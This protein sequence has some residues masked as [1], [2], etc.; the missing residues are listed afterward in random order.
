MAGSLKSRLA[1]I[2][3]L[4]IALLSLW[5]TVQQSRIWRISAEE[6]GRIGDIESKFSALKP[7][8]AGVDLVGYLASR[9]IGASAKDEMEHS[10]ARYAL[11]PTLVCTH[12][13]KPYVVTNFDTGRELDA[14]LRTGE[15]QLVAR[16]GPGLAVLRRVSN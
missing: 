9:T 3:A 11:V 14:L 10:L 4:A 13:N 15:F 7:Y 12:P 2:V 16:A 6:P 5:L 1:D 8:L